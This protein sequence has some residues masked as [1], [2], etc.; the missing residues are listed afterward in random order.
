MED[1]LP[2]A[3]KAQKNKQRANCWSIRLN[4]PVIAQ[5][6]HGTF[7]NDYLD[8]ALAPCNKSG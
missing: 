1:Y 3:D 7:H 4:F 5:W 2:F 8:M 6:S